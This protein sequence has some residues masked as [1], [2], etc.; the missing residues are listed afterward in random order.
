MLW[1]GI[2]GLGYSM[3]NLEYYE[4]PELETLPG[5]EMLGKHGEPPIWKNRLVGKKPEFAYAL[6]TFKNPELVHVGIWVAMVWYR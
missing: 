2:G 3:K 4:T 1:E 5:W 6:K